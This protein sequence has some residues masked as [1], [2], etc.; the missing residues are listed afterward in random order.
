[1]DLSQRILKCLNERQVRLTSQIAGVCSWLQPPVS[2][3]TTGWSTP[4]K[5]QKKDHQPPASPWG[6]IRTHSPPKET[7]LPDL[8]S[9]AP[10]SDLEASQKQNVIFFSYT[11]SVSLKLTNKSPSFQIC[12]SG[13]SEKLENCLQV[14]R[15]L[16]VE[17]PGLKSGAPEPQSMWPCH[18]TLPSTQC[19]SSRS[20]LGPPWKSQAWVVHPWGNSFVVDLER[21]VCFFLNLKKNLLR[22]QEYP[23]S[24][25][26]IKMWPSLQRCSD[27]KNF[28][29]IR[30]KAEAGNVNAQSGRLKSISA[31]QEH[32]GKKR[33]RSNPSVWLV[34]HIK[35]NIHDAA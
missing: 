1:M 19:G 16:S 4:R 2:N 30:W 15:L 3:C 33:S 27:L 11:P 25:T 18:V 23:N 29:D 34:C 20:S 32:R 22:N 6:F 21:F 5:I 35:V 13:R 17:H 14:T 10:R 8:C 24:S 9:P 28:T 12:A 31:E 26:R 7:F